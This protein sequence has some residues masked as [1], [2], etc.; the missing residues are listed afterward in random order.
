MDRE[1]TRITR[2]SASSVGKM[3]VIVARTNR[4]I[5]PFS[6]AKIVRTTGCGTVW[7][8]GWALRTSPRVGRPPIESPGT[9]TRPTLMAMVTS[10]NLRE[11]IRAARERNENIF[12]LLRSMA[13]SETDIHAKVNILERLAV[14]LEI[15]D[16]LDSAESVYLE[17][18]GLDPREAILWCAL[19]NFYRH[20]D[21]LDEAVA[22]IE[23]AVD[24]SLG[25]ESLVR[26]VHA[27]RI[28]IGL[29]ANRMDMVEDSLQTLIAF[30][31]TPDR[32]DR[33]LDGDFIPALEQ[34]PADSRL[35]EA[36]Q[37]R[38]ESEKKGRR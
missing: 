19:A 22:A 30:D 20:V 23:R 27:S 34:S 21:K 31:P 6:A 16:D 13:S 12:D 37:R 14:E 1:T 32:P 5:G 24:P 25:L 28:R 36:Y 3:S 29:A 10:R 17:L 11:I 35:V 9:G 26:H 18:V 38:F 33:P 15:A 7:G 4:T 2:R 8:K